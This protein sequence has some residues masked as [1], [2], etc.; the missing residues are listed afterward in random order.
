MAVAKMEKINIIAHRDY[1]KRILELL[2]DRG[3]MEII[4]PDKKEDGC[5]RG[6]NDSRRTGDTEYE[7]AKIKYALEFLTPFF[8]DKRSLV[9]KIN[10][11]RPRFGYDEIKK[12]KDEYDYLKIADLAEESNRNLNTLKSLAVKLEDE[13]AALTPWS[14]LPFATAGDLETINVKV[15][16]GTI[17]KQKSEGLAAALSEEFRL[18]EIMPIGA[19]ETTL[20]LAII[21]F[22]KQEKEVASVLSS[23]EF[24]PVELPA[25][26]TVPR[27]R[28][29]AIGGELAKT[30]AAITAA[31]EAARALSRDHLEKLRVVFDYL[32]WGKEREQIQER[33]VFTEKSFS[34]LGWVRASEL[35]ELK[36]AIESVTATAEVITLPLGE[37]ESVPVV[38]ENRKLIRPFEFVTGIYGFPKHTEVDPT[39]F[40][41]GFFVV[42]FG[43]CLTDAGYGLVVLIGTML[44]LKFLR[45]TGGFKKLLQVLFYGSIL[46]IIAGGLTGGWFGITLDDLPAGLDW[47]SGPLIALRQI[48]P[49]KDPIIML[50][51]S[52]ILGYI[53]LFFGCTIDLWWK[54]KHGETK[55]GLLGPAVWMYFL[56]SIGLWIIAARGIALASLAKP[57]LY[58]VYS[59][60][61]LIICTQGKGKNPVA[62]IMGGLA[63]LY[64]GLTGY[65]SDI[66]SYSRLLALGLATGIIAMVVNIV[67]I[68]M[69]DMIPFVGWIIMILVLIGGHAMNL[70]I[71]LVGAFIHS[72]RLQYVE[73]FKRFFMGGGKEFAPFARESKYVEL[74]KK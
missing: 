38:M 21:L 47:L 31:E 29:A 57:A 73:F 9:E 34:I 14:G 36:I 15:V 7:L 60:V 4:A 72:G 63:E 50:I 30:T 67:A 61:A 16:L 11:I 26:D 62:K 22:K 19:D 20:Y 5:G 35:K 65:I 48:N 55:E 23:R 58:M 44:A 1:K 51:L 2:Y 17:E 45:F 28:I 40:L 42:F 3:F 43:L 27:E 54:I 32:S 33:F 6:E 68:M 41:A 70:V 37:D 13:R 52:I 74:V 18:T 8:V 24:K 69:K 10:G 25:L 49:V 12:L 59:S 46:T 64:F 39:P 71:N 56:L 53:H 66:L